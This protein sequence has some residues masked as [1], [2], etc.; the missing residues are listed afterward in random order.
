ML[1]HVEG[2]DVGSGAAEGAGDG[3]EAARP[4]GQLETQQVGHVCMV[5]HVCVVQVTAPVLCRS[6]LG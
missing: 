2:E 4:V 1:D 3:S 6:R 5:P